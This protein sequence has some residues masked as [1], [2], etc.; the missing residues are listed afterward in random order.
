[1]PDLLGYVWTET[2]SGKKKL[3]ITTITPAG[4]RISTFIILV[5]KKDVS[6]E[7]LAVAGQINICHYP[8]KTNTHT[9]TV[10]VSRN[11]NSDGHGA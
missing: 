5:P 4:R 11:L 10:N 7:E 6:T 9:Q 8:K 3:R 2:V 1:M